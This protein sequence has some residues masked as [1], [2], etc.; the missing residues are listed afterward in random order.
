MKIGPITIIIIGFSLALIA[1]FYAFFHHWQPNQQTAEHWG[2]Y[3]G[4]LEREAGKLKQAQDRKRRAEEMVNERAREWQQVV[5]VR[6]PPASLGAGGINL[7]VNAWQLTVD[8]RTFRNNVQRAV[9]RQLRSGGVRVISGPSVPMP[10]DNASAIVA[11]YFN[12]PAIPFP[13]VIYDL[14]QVTVQGTYAQITANMRA[15][16]TMPNYLAVADGLR[17]DGTGQILTGTYNLTVVGYL[18][19]PAV[20]PTVPEAGGGA[21]GG[22]PPGGAGG[23]GARRGAV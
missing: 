6:T 22:A 4:E 17:V 18:R 10:D 2:R 3:A 1:V 12:Y 11:N 20:Y 9:N 16:S 21:P 5:A 7:A 8:A 14:G 13:V 15:W 23:G 19:A